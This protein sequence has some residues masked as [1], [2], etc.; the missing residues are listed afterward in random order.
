MEARWWRRARLLGDRR[1]VGDLLLWA[2]LAAP[3]GFAGIT[4][5]CPPAAVLLL[6][7]S[8]ALLALAVG[9]GRRLPLAALLAVVL[10]SLLDGNFV[11]AIPVFSYLAG[12]R[13]A[14]P[15]GPPGSSG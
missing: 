8:L 6:T 5:P 14:G 11:F 9:I 3:I 4:P 15:P 7:A 2:A 10:G 12:R 1:R 13:G